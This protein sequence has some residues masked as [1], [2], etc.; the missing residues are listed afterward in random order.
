[1]SRLLTFERQRCM[2]LALALTLVSTARMPAQMHL[3][4]ASDRA[5]FRSWFVLLADA[6]FETAAGEVTDCAALIRFAY[7]EADERS[8][9]GNFTRYGLELRICQQHEP[10]AERRAIGRV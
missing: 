1:M 4:D 10:R 6:Q 5:A 2:A 9:V 8:A 3:S 7:R